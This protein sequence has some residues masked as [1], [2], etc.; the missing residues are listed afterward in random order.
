MSEN[1][2]K[3]ALLAGIARVLMFLNNVPSNAKHVDVD[4]PIFW[5]IVGSAVVWYL[6]KALYA[7]IETIKASK[8]K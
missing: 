4:I 3:A 1:F 5:A 7:A 8:R 2:I 6:M